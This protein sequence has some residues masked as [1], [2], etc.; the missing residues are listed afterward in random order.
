MAI[1][2]CG[3]NNQPSLL[4]PSKLDRYEKPTEGENRDKQ[5]KG[6]NEEG[7]KGR[8]KKPNRKGE[9]EDNKKLKHKKRGRTENQDSVVSR[10]FY[11]MLT[12]C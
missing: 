10:P 12:P 2:S 11:L 5:N 9:R 6:G 3:N 1:K 8:I 7:E 4:E